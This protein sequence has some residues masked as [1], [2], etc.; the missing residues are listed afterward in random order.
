[1]RYIWHQRQ[2]YFGRER[3]GSLA[4]VILDRLLEWLRRWDHRTAAHVSH[5][6]AISRTVQERIRECYNRPSHV[7]YPPV[8]TDFYSPANCHRA[9]Y[10]LIVSAF[11]P[12]KRLDTAITACN[13]LQ[14]KLVIIG[15]GQDEKR[16][17]GLA[18]P[19]VHFLGWQSNT[20]VRDHL[21]RARALL[22]PGEED[23]GIVP[24]EA[25]ACGTPVIAL[26]RGG[27]METVVGANHASGRPTEP[28][29][30]FFFEPSTE[31]LIEAIQEFERCSSNFDPATAR[32][33]AQ[34]FSTPRFEEEFF[35][36]V[37]RVLTQR[38]DYRKAA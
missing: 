7:I 26:C 21:R 36:Y 25:M 33:Q 16:L 11:A 30:L 15:T 37:D 2:A 1:M 8:D 13:R 5:F 28:T 18:G 27:A 17:R 29:G 14:Q 20:V 19:T 34:Q 6:L 31:C 23:F 22:F 9:N 24:V 12:Y 35:G 3:I 38:G 4:G 32:R 10:Y